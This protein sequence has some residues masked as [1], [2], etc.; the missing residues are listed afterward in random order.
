VTTGAAYGA[1]VASGVALGVV[2]SFQFSWDV[3]GVPVAALALTIVNLVV[4]RAAGWAMAA[5]LGAVAVAVPWL[6]VV[7]LLSTPR[8]EGDLVVTGTL[9]GWLFILG[10][11][12]AAALAIVWTPSTW[13]PP[14]PGQP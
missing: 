13:S 2:G 5:K 4:F 14:D 6:V 7:I 11:A 1:L 12:T 10:G 8:A 3:G 9:A